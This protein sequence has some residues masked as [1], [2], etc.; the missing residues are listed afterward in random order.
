MKAVAAVPVLATQP[1]GGPGRA[2]LLLGRREAWRMLR[3]PVYV[4]A[5]VGLIA[6]GSEGPMRDARF[7]AQQAGQGTLTYGALATLFA[8]N[9]VASSARR[10]GAAAQLGAV[11]LDPQLR[12]ASVCLGVLAGPVA[13]AGLLTA[14]LAWIERDLGPA[15]AT[16]YR[17]QYGV[18][19]GWEYAQ[20]P[21]IWLGAGLLGVAV[22]RWLPWP[23]APWPPWWH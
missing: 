9:L 16:E 3:H 15:A 13:L 19:H 20:L 17:G 23:G 14:A 1:S 5:V 4:L 7:V 22:A 2:V 11:P 12:T 10:T 6:A 18:H 21:L 8:A